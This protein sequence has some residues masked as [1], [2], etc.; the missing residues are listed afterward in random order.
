MLHCFKPVLLAFTGVTIIAGTVLPSQADDS[1]NSAAAQYREKDFGAAYASA[2]KSSDLTHR[3]FVRG[4]AALRLDKFEEAAT[5]LAEAEQKLPLVADYAVYFQAEALLKQKKYLAASAK[6]ASI[7]TLFPSSKTVRR[8]EKLYADILFEA[9]DYKG[10]LKLFQSYIE[11]YPSGADAIDASFS[12][13]RCRE[14][15]ADAEGALLVY[16]TI[17][18]NNPASPLAARAQERIKQL[19]KSGLKSSPYTAEE[20]L[21]RASSLYAQSEYSASLKT[22]DMIPTLSQSQAIN[23]RIEL[24]TGMAHYRLRQYKKAEK[25][26]LKAVAS[27]LPGVRSE[28]RFWLAKSLE[29][30]E[31]KEQALAMYLELAGE[32]KKQEFAD[33][34][35]IE[36]AGLKRGLEQYAEAA[37]LFD[38]AA[39][40]STEPKTIAKSVWDSGWC[41]YLAGE[42][43]AAA[44]IFKGLLSDE[45]QREK[46]LYWLGRTLEK[47]G[48]AAALS[49]FRTLLDEFPA[50]FYATW[51]REQ[52]GVKDSREP[53][54]N[55]DALAEL[56]LLSGFDKPRLLA[57]LGMLEEA[58]TE[59][60]VIRKKNGEKK[61]LFPALARIYLEI[62]DFGSAISLFL[63]NRPVAWEK[64]TLPLWTAGYPRVY[65]E[66]V[67]QNA[68]LNGL[69]EGLVYALIR[70]ESGFSPAVK[71][72]AGA[73]GL[74][75][76]MPA[77]A[78]LTAR[79]KGDFNPQRL[80]VPEYNIRLGTKHL[81]D[82]M[83]EHNG[84]V[85]SVAAAYNAGSAALERW[86]KSFKGL[87]KDEFIESIPYQ[88]TRDYVKKVYA[89]AAT[90]RQ[91]YGL[92]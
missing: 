67:S 23:N 73:I 24:R 35:F 18:L 5:L 81:H 13:A 10:A 6:A 30:Q 21:K 3:A 27:P 36:A 70:A 2:G 56:P 20:L 12:S 49:C 90:Y 43:P 74:M 79:E 26:F 62:R 66:L 29:R 46:T 80:T 82:L 40:L 4:M 77:T 57:S 78:K 34:A 42:Y 68:A 32:G 58:R 71:S 22:L 15:S 75:Q 31:L 51:Y 50:G 60:A 53:L 55:R 89:S 25:Q 1:L 65:A 33:D 83:K 38:Q 37:S 91:L 19:E 16:R 72:S 45:N 39:R 54:G 9:G 47:N 69:S 7:Q 52:K 84:D 61:S 63:Q 11:K 14:E 41:R 85:V 88:E 17:W 86:K 44:E 92:K 28:A 76:M 59:M 87:K 64:G 48:D 8:S